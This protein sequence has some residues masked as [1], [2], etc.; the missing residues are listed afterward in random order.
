MRNTVRNAEAAHHRSDQPAAQ[1]PEHST[2]D[3]VFLEAKSFPS[4]ADG[5]ADEAERGRPSIT[6]EQLSAAQLA[7]QR[8]L[9]GL[10]GPGAARTL[11]G[12]APLPADAR[13]PRRSSAG[14]GR[15]APPRTSGGGEGERCQ[16]NAIMTTANSSGGGGRG[17]NLW[18]SPESTPCQSPRDG[19]QGRA[20]DSRQVSRKAPASPE[21]LRLTPAAFCG[22][23]D[24]VMST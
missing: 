20:P 1:F 9:R 8:S 6:K 7:V 10:M 14:G 19:A 18:L 22:L 24:A 15:A 5:G 4:G 13:P 23:S 17:N 3:G 11:D 2:P 16:G 12:E 21:R